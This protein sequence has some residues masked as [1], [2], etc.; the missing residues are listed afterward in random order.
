MDAPKGKVDAKVNEPTPVELTL[1]ETLTQ[2]IEKFGSAATSQGVADTIEELRLETISNL[3]VKVLNMIGLD[4]FDKVLEPWEKLGYAGYIV[5]R[6]DVGAPK[7][8]LY[9]KGKGTS[10]STGNTGSSN[11]AELFTMLATDE[12]KRTHDDIPSTEK[13]SNTK[14]WTIKKKVVEGAG[15]SQPFKGETPPNYVWVK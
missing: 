12:E 6:D 9:N 14:K 3:G 8:Y 13:G 4:K 15:Y 10:T 7:I 11:L 2:L 5:T 1:E